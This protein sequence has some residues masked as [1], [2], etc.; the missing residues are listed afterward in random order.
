[1]HVHVQRRQFAHHLRDQ[2]AELGTIGDARDQRLVP[3][4]HR[5]PVDAVHAAVVEAVALLPPGVDEDLPPFVARIETKRPFTQRHLVFEVSA[6]AF[7]AT[8]LAALADTEASPAHAPAL[9]QRRLETLLAAFKQAGV[10]QARLVES[11]LVARPDSTE[12]VIELNLLEPDRP[13][14]SQL[15]Q[16]LRGLGGTTPSE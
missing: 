2:V 7:A 14:R 4:P 15:L 6:G 11:A 10:P 13:R 8:T 9:A 16:T 12:G 3:R 5:R 1:M